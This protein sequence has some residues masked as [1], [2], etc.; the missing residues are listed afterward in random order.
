MSDKINFKNKLNLQTKFAPIEFQQAQINAIQDLEYAA[1]FDE[2]GLGKTKISIDI[3]L[4]WLSMNYVDTIVIFT[5]KILVNNWKKELTMHTN[6]KPAVLTSNK[7]Q[8]HSLFNSDR[9][10]YISNF[11]A[12]KSEHEN[13]TFLAQDRNLGVIL[14]ESAKIKN[15]ESELTKLF[16]DYSLLISRKLILT[17]TPVANRPYDL[18]SQIFFLD[19]GQALGNNF[20]EFKNNTDLPRKNITDNNY[21]RAL[22]TVFPRLEAFCFRETKKSVNIALPPID[23]KT[24]VC[25]WETHQR[26]MYDDILNEIGITVIRD[27]VSEYD[28]SRDVIK[29][30]LRLVQVASNPVLLDDTYNQDT[31]KFIELKKLIKKIPQDDKIIIWTSFVNN[32]KWLGK[33]LT[34]LKVDNRLIHGGLSISQRNSN[35][36][37]FENEPS[38]RILVA[39]PG[40]AKEGLTLTCANHAIYYD[41]NF[42]LDDFLQSKARIHRISQEKKCMIYLLKTIDSIDNW[43]SDY[44]YMKELA[45]KLTQQDITEEE[46]N[47][48]VPRDLKTQLLNIL[49]MG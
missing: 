38:I 41:R 8:N 9:R 31:G 29:K 34:F 43:L 24:I 4:H 5:K 32:V 6:L 37:L 7:D 27:G 33:E 21:A 47:A 16:L 46:F 48:K 45:A 3:F 40:A 39:N 11:E 49:N 22:M 19:L 14:D 18:W 20:L 15:P 35:L 2:Q 25:N 13:F 1:I 17:G 36:Y 23:T 28:I 42:T 10:I 30:L 44:I 12:L 26:Q